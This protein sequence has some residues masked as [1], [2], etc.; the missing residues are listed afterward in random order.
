MGWQEDMNGRQF[1]LIH[2]ISMV[3]CLLLLL[4]VF[5]FADKRDKTPMEH[6]A[7]PPRPPTFDKNI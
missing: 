1:I 6:L 3:A 7:A 5:N 2:R 4:A